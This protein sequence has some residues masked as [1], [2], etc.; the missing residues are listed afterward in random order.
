MKCFCNKM[1][2]ILCKICIILSC[3]CGLIILF[4]SNSIAFACKK[5]FLFDNVELF[6][7][8]LAPMFLLY[9][10]YNKI[11]IKKPEVCFYYKERYIVVFVGIALCIQLIASYAALFYTGWDSDL[12]TN[13]AY[14]IANGNV[15]TVQSDYFSK[16]PNNMFLLWM[17][18]VAFRIVRIVGFSDYYHGILSIVFMQ[19]IISSCAGYLLYNVGDKISGSHVVALLSWL[20]YFLFIGMSPWMMIPYSDATGLIFPILLVC[21]YYMEM[22]SRYTIPYWIL[23]TGVSYVG[24]K[25]KPQVMICFIA[26]LIVD[27]WNAKWNDTIVRNRQLLKGIVIA[28]TFVLCFRGTRV[29]EASL[30]LQTDS[31]AQFGMAHYAMMGLNE[32]DGVYLQEDEDYSQSFK[33][34]KDRNI[35]DLKLAQER[36]SNYG[37]CGLVKHCIKKILVTYDDGTFA[38]SIEGGFYREEFN[39]RDRVISPFFKDMY[40]ADRKNYKYYST[41]MQGMWIFLLV[42]TAIFSMVKTNIKNKELSYIIMLSLLGLLLFELLFEARARYLYIFSP[43][44][45]I[46]GIL[47]WNDT[48]CYVKRLLNREKQRI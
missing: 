31:D 5:E 15:A 35:A 45:V 16:Y 20:F 21:L 17:Y 10:V 23:I 37:F 27:M 4:G 22:Q 42:G 33:N 26:I 8:V 39:D 3:V 43:F 48:F 25:I 2:T 40:Y 9:V 41:V 44:F 46:C 24:Y 34:Q 19:C 12:L 28:T 29:M 38:W 14:A 7:I 11:L 36:I 1:V 13:S 18:T 32:N 30:G 47:G 6:A